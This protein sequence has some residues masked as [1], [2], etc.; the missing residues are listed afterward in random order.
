MATAAVV[1]QDL[2]QAFLSAGAVAVISRSPSKPNSSAAEIATYFRE[3][4][5]VLF[6]EHCSIIE[7]VNAVGEPSENTLCCAWR[8][9]AHLG[10]VFWEIASQAVWDAMLSSNCVLCAC[11][12]KS[13]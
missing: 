1:P 13:F 2:V 7:A 10:Q 9:F 6:E 3:L 11:L 5:T 8:H 4:Y 12:S